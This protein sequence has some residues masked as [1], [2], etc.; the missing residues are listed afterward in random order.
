M[1]I[2]ELSTP[3]PDSKDLYFPTKYSR[4]VYTQCVAC[5]WKQ[6]WS[7]WRNL[8][9]C[10]ETTLYDRHCADVRNNVLG[11]WFQK[12]SFLPHYPLHS[13]D[14]LVSILFLKKNF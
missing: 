4:S 11:S 12:V 2:E 13:R 10:G 5:L 3:T 7:N 1:L 9:L 14:Y 6:H 8:V